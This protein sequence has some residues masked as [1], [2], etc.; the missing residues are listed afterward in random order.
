MKNQYSRVLHDLSSKPRQRLEIL[1]ALDPSERGFILLA[2]SRLV[3]KKLLAELQTNEIVDVVH[4]LDPDDTTDLLQNLSEKRRN[5]IIKHLDQATKDKVEFLLR[6]DPRTAAGVMS[7]DY[8][9]VQKGIK[10]KDVFLLI[11]KHEIR[12]GKTPA[13]LVIESG[14]LAGEIPWSVLTGRKAVQEIDKYIKKI[15]TIRFD[16]KE[17][18]VVKRFRSHPHNTI[19]VLDEDNTILGVIYSDDVLRVIEKTASKDLY[20]FAGVKEEESV[21]DPV[22][23]KVRHRYKWLILNLFTGFLVAGVVV[24]F[25]ETITA[26]VLLAAYMPI[27]AGMGGNAGVQTLAVTVRGIT[28]KEIELKTAKK[29]IITEMLAGGI[30]GII[31]GTIVAIIATLW[32]KSA[33]L[34]LAIG[35]SMVINLMIAGIFG[36]VV[37]LIMKVLNKDPA[38]SA[39]IFI[40]TAT[41]MCGFFIFLGLA[42]LVL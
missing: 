35:L 11:K 26:F 32:N 42:S 25:E 7:L 10:F 13:I 36:S 16:R 21:N 15:P 9:Q 20:S 31:V 18:E 29:T 39:T 17:D 8:I 23:T 19:A 12:T 24:M 37:P 5:K 28:L 30:N 38:T 14:F 1:L 4:Y 33:L 6:F 34:G 22:F 41:D 40:T 2:C 27:V 3:R